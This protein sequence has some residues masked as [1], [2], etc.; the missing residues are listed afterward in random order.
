MPVYIQLQENPS[1]NYD[2]AEVFPLVRKGDSVVVVQFVDS[3]IAKQ[4][5]PGAALPPFMKK[6]DKLNLYFV[7][8]DVIK[9]DSAY[10]T[11]M[12]KELAKDR[13]RQE[14]EHAQETAKRRKEI[15]EMQEKEYAE[16][17]KTGEV[18]KQ[19]KVVTDYLAAKKITATKTGRG[20]FVA[21]TQ[22]GTGPKA[23]VGKFLTVKYSGRFLRND[24]T[25]QANTYPGLEL[26]VGAVIGGWDEGLQLFNEGGKGTIYIPGFLAYGKNPNPNSPFKPDDA[27][28]FDVEVVKVSNTPE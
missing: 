11:D 5:N 28:I 13:P 25:F 23:E 7:V 21:I 9:T 10:Q 15:M 12:Q 24:S 1:L 2:P 20:T 26:G 8:L 17:Q 6:G 16:L 3:L 18:D 14:K 4:N 22:Q 19:I 27:L